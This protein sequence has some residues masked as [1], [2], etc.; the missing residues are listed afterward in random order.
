[1][2]NDIEEILFGEEPVVQITGKRGRPKKSAAELSETTKRKR[3]N[4]RISQIV[5]QVKDLNSYAQENDWGLSLGVELV[6]QKEFEILRKISINPPTTS[7]DSNLLVTNVAF[8]KTKLTL[9]LLIECKH[10]HLTTGTTS[11]TKYC[12]LYYLPQKE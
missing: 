3:F 11:P 4:N 1:M 10:T 7:S 12:R 6:V 5:D 9:Q 2:I 8:L